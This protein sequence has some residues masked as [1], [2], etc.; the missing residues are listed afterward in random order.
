[1]TIAICLSES[2]SQ[3][4]ARRQEPEVSQEQSRALSQGPVFIE[5]QPSTWLWAGDSAVSRAPPAQVEFTTGE[6]DVDRGW[7]GGQGKL[8]VYHLLSEC[9]S[10]LGTGIQQ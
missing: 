3:H 10:V 5:H 2:R 8:E 9:H 6:A 1:M 4:P 7:S